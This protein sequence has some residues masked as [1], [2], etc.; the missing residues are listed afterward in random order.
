MVRAPRRVD[1]PHASS[2]FTD[3]EPHFLPLSGYYLPTPT[4]ANPKDCQ[5]CPKNTYLRAPKPNHDLSSA[6]CLACPQYTVS[7]AGS[8]ECQ[9]ACPDGLVT[10]AGTCISCAAGH[11]IDRKANACLEC[12]AGRFGGAGT[13]CVTCPF[14]SNCPGGTSCREG[15]DGYLCARCVVGKATAFPLNA[16]RSSV[17]GSDL[18]CSLRACGRLLSQRDRR[19]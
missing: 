3:W 9:W 7:D 16:A 2:L 10:T 13:A 1:L 8:S 4:S 15:S 11:V 6:Y 18:P 19:L 5:P 12:P 14:E 17:P